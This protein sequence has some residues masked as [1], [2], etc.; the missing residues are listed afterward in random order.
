MPDELILILV[1]LLGLSLYVFLGGADFGFGIWSLLLKHRPGPERDSLS[2]AMGPLWEANHVWLV[3]CLVLMLGAFPAGLAGLSQALW[4]PLLFAL[5]AILFRGAAFAL[6]QSYEGRPVTQAR[7]ETVFGLSSLLAPFCFG[8]GVGVWALGCLQFTP[9]GLFVASSQTQAF[10]PLVLTGGVF[11]SV[12][13]AWLAAVFLFHE[14]WRRKD[15]K[16]AGLWLKRALIT[17][18]CVNGLFILVLAEQM[19]AG[20][21]LWK[22]M[23]ARSSFNMLW[24]MLFT[25]A[26]MFLMRFK[27]AAS[28]MLAAGAAV[29][30]AVFGLGLGAYP[31]MV[32]GQITFTDM[33]APPQTLHFMVKVIGAGLVFLVPCLVLL[34]WVFRGRKK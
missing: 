28:A 9:E 31:F 34:F 30:V 22:Q 11:A 3:L 18:V 21:A 19:A 6:R 29:T 7:W 16:Q 32:F 10:P 2:Q 5:L 8:A 1:F 25:S 4:L 14:S 33:A 12:L 26:A 15:K 20:S 17:G 24:F 13:A 23:L 27:Q